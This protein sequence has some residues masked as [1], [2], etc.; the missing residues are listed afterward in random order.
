MRIERIMKR[1]LELGLRR[2]EKLH[3]QDEQLIEVVRLLLTR[4]RRLS[5]DAMRELEHL[6]EGLKKENKKLKQDLDF[7]LS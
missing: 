6:A 1:E 3:R 2:I 5:P 4:K 7:F